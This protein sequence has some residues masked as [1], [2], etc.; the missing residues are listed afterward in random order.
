MRALWILLPIMALTS[1]DRCLAAEEQVLRGHVPRAVRE[2]NLRAAGR[3]AET[4][5]LTLAIGLPW[6]NQE[7]LH[8]LLRQI[9][10][11]SSP[12]YHHYLTPE[13]F[14][15]RFAPTEQDYE[16]VITFARGHGLE[17]LA[18]YGNRVLLDVRGSVSSIERSLHVKM[19]VFQ[20]PR[21]PRTFYAPDREPSLDLAVP[22]LLHVSG[23]DDYTRPHPSGMKP[24]P[25]GG[26][27][28]G[29]PLGGT[30]SGMFNSFTAHDLRTAYVPGVSL[31]GSGQV[32]GLFEMDGYYTND[33]GQYEKT[34]SLTNV[35]L[36]NV[37]L[38]NFNGSPSNGEYEVALDIE[39][40]M[41][42]APGL[43]KIVVYEGGPNGM[44]DDILNC[45]ATNNI[46]KQLSSSWT[47][48]TDATTEQIFQELA[49]QG[50]SFFQAS[51]DNGAYSGGVTA[52]CDDPYI[53]IV[54]GTTLTTASAGGA[55]ASETV[56]YD[57]GGGISA[58]Y[59]IPIWQ[60]GVDMSSNMG[61]STMR[62]VPDVSC[63]ADTVFSVVEDGVPFAASGTSASAPLWAGFI[64]LANQQA[65]AHGQASLGFVNPAIYAIGEAT[66]YDADF[67]DITTGNNT[68]AESPHAYFAVAGYDL[69]TGWGTP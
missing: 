22:L 42:M 63:V 44:P 14:S 49:A 3:L 20:H 43:A 13:E 59:A 35:P 33:I 40:A 58:T 27:A 24:R 37:Y 51:G 25:L 62:N 61:S 30:G 12:G 1:V 55:W 19:N 9:Y 48:A 60:A 52:P 65:E 41:A 69:C 53:T 26:L 67:H 34:N 15:Q 23:L 57:S 32:V 11:P 6:R 66:N 50:Q 29:K 56:W 28:G 21:E 8:R 4:N 38:D 47:F 17:P 54:G 16:A 46:A 36:Q 18:S 7:S 68:N 39:M 2:L 31:T 10:D 5:R 45:M 64:A